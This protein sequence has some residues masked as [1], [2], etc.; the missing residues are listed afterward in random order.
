MKEETETRKRL[1]ET[2]LAAP[3][4]SGVYQWKDETGCVIYVGK[5]K[6]LKNRLSSYFT[7]NRDI[8]TRILV[9]RANSIEYITTENEYEAL[10]LEN[11]L[12][13]KWSPRYNINLKDGK[14][15]PVIK[16][17]NEKFPRVFRTRTIRNDGARYFGPFPNVPAID[18]FLEFVKRNYRLRQCKTLKARGAPCMYYH[19][20]RCGAPCCG[21]ISEEEYARELEELLLLLDGDQGPALDRL[22][23]MMRDAAKTLMFE[24]AARI[25]DGIG[26]IGELREQNAVVD[27]DPESRDYVAW[28]AEGIMVTFAVL[29]MRS[30]RL[31]GR[32]LYRV[33]SL[34]DEEEI[35]PEFLM[36]YYT[37][38]TRVPPRIFVPTMSGLALAERWF[39]EALGVEVQIEAIAIEDEPTGESS[40]E[41]SG[42]T[43]AEPAGKYAAGNQLPAGEQNPTGEHI[44]AGNHTPEGRRH[45]AAMAMARFNAKT[46]AARRLREHGDFPALEEL[47]KVLGLPTLPSR[48]EGF[49]IAHIGGR[50]PVASL[51]SFRDGNPDRKNYRMFRLRTTDGVIDDFASM[52]EVTTR[53][54]SRLINEGDELPDLIMID[55][56]I[57]QVNAVKGV[58]DALGA[59][60]PIVGLAKQ[61]EEL[62]LP[63]NSTPLRLPRRS[64]ALRLLQRVRDETHR[65]ATTRNQRL[66]TKENTKLIFESLPG[67][68]PKKATKLL[69]RFGGLEGLAEA[70]AREDGVAEIAKAI[71]VGEEAAREIAQAVPALVEARKAERDARAQ[72]GTPAHEVGS[73]TDIAALA[74]LAAGD[75]GDADS[76]A[77]QG[78]PIGP[79]APSA[80]ED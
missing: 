68:G 1:H 9:S 28:A 62:Y 17:T 11:T 14:T 6:N 23:A 20:G 19:I 69:E 35:I 25:R 66:R 59:E 15:Y 57:G 72:T 32:D 49:D 29:Q 33:R 61:D 38:P 58:L 5:A 79:N 70:A 75:A 76:P 54:Y 71:A 26:A 63:G 65:F 36:A 43:V 7:S 22:N 10:L 18:G 13:K 44:P 46:D 53:R 21:K 31:V 77:G 52:R 74:R 42:D 80:R 67:V 51:I 8:K 27:M 48:I 37:D 12:I 45:R 40:G 47:K 55:G 16:V 3:K 41:S 2:A 78:T 24:R 30:G 50:L 34:K 64:D 39:R 56:G 60:I 4:S 73:A